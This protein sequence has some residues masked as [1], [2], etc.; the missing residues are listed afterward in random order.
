GQNL[1]C[2]IAIHLKAHPTSC[3][4]LYPAFTDCNMINETWLPIGDFDAMPVFYDLASYTVHEFGLTWPAEWGSTSWI[5][6]KGDIAVGTILLP[7]EGTAIAWTVCQFGWGLATGAAWLTA[8]GPGYVTPV[9]NPATMQIDVVDC[10][11]VTG[12]YQDFPI[13]I[14]SGG[15]GGLAGDDPCRTPPTAVEPSTWGQIKSIFK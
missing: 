3:T 6:C 7:G 11:F 9:A 8:T 4:K 14:S 12:P 1:G 10:D 2:K 13:L 5:R 15:V